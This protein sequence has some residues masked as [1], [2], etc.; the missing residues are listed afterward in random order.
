MREIQ[1]APIVTNWFPTTF[2]SFEYLDK[3]N[4]TK[5][6]KIDMVCMSLELE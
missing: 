1:N 6:V 4:L 5:L 2:N 3:F